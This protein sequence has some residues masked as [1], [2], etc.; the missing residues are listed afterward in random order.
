VGRRWIVEVGPG[1]YLRR[2]TAFGKREKLPVTIPYAE[3]FVTKRAA[4]T[5]AKRFGYKNPNV[6]RTWS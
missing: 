6:V 3:K 2:K 5:A 1:L 4:I